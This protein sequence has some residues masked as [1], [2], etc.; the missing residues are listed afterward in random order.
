MT[1]YADTFMSDAIKNNDDIGMA[2]LEEPVAEET[3][4]YD[5]DG[6]LTLI[7]E[8]GRSQIVLTII[9]CFLMIPTAC[10]VLIMT[11]LGVNPP[12]T[13]NNGSIECNRAGVFSV[14]HEFY[15][16]R[17]VMKRESWRFVKEKEFSIVTE[18]DNILVFHNVTKILMM[19]W[20]ILLNCCAL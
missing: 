11:F 12:W 6:I 16:R 4:E 19:R 14:N 13:C 17:C 18:V 1:K 8:F 15:Y 10:Q 3:K 5:V 9:L 7:G 2:I 20:H